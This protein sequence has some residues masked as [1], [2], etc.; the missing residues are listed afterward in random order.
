MKRKKGASIGSANDSETKLQKKEAREQ[1]AREN[2]AKSKDL[3]VC[4]LLG[5]AKA[6]LIG[7]PVLTLVLS[8]CILVIPLSITEIGSLMGV[9]ADETRIS[10]III[11]LVMPAMFM[12]LMYAFLTL[13]LVKWWYRKVVLWVQS[14]YQKH[15]GKASNK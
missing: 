12:V 2:E 9:L 7:I 4:L 3:L 8:E 6:V 14:L 13:T 15:S 10:Y 1:R 5:F 11:L